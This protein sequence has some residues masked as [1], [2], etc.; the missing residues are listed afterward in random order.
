MIDKIIIFNTESLEG[1]YNANKGDKERFY[2]EWN[3]SKHTADTFYQMIKY[4][5]DNT[6][7]DSTINTVLIRQLIEYITPIIEFIPIEEKVEKVIYNAIRQKKTADVK[8]PLSKKKIVFKVE[9]NITCLVHKSKKGEYIVVSKGSTI[10]IIGF[11]LNKNITRNS[12]YIYNYITNLDNGIEIQDLINSGNI[13]LFNYLN[14]SYFKFGAKVDFSQKMFYFDDVKKDITAVLNMIIKL[15]KAATDYYDKNTINLYKTIHLM[16]F[17]GSL[18]PPVRETIKPKCQTII[19]KMNKILEVDLC[20]D[21]HNNIVQ[22]LYNTGYYE[23]FNKLNIGDV[24]TYSK[25]KYIMEKKENKIIQTNLVY[26]QLTSNNKYKNVTDE[27]KAKIIAINDAINNDDK[28]AIK[29]ALSKSPPVCKHLIYKGELLLKDDGKNEVEKN[30][31]IRNSLISNYSD[32]TLFDG[33]FCKLCGEELAKIDYTPQIAVETRN[34]YTNETYNELQVKIYREIS[35]IVTNFVDFGKTH[36]HSISGIIKNITDVIKGEMH[37]IEIGLLKIKTLQ[38]NEVEFTLGIYIYIYAFAF[39][40][41]LIYLNDTISFKK[42]LFHGGKVVVT[43]AKVAKVTTEPILAK[44]AENTITN[45]K[46]LQKIINSAI[47]ILTKIKA[48]DLQKSKVIS[49]SSIKDL[50]LKAYRWVLNINYA[51]M[52]YSTT[53]YWSQNNNIIDYFLY[54]HNRSLKSKGNS[55]ADPITAVLGRS[56]KTIEAEL[57]KNV[58]IYDTIIKPIKWSDNPYYNDSLLAIYDYINEQLYLENVLAKNSS[59]INYYAKYSY[60]LELQK[61]VQKQNKIREI[62]PFSRMPVIPYKHVKSTSG[63][64][65]CNCPDSKYIYQKINN[66]GNT[67]GVKREVSNKDINDWLIVKDYKKINE[68]NAWVVVDITCPCKKSKSTT[69]IDAF[70]NFYNLKCPVGDAHEFSIKNN[71]ECSKCHI[72]QDFIDNLNIA[73]YK[74]YKNVYEATKIKELS[75]FKL[76]KSNVKGKTAVKFP[77]YVK[78]LSAIK[79]LVLLLNINPNLINNL[80]LY[81]KQE[82]TKNKFD[83]DLSV[84]ITEMERLKQNNNLY[85]HYLFIIRTYYFVRGSDQSTTIPDY[86]VDFIKSFSN[87]GLIEKFPMIN[88]NF[89]DMYSYYKKHMSA[90]L[91]TNFLLHSIASTLLQ[92]LAIYEK[93]SLAVVGKKFIK[94]LFDKMID[95]EKKLTKFDIH[96]ILRF[97]RKLESDDSPDAEIETTE[98][99]GDYDIVDADIDVDYEEDDAEKDIFSIGDMDV[100]MDDDNLY[101]DVEDRT[102]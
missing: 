27:D 92:I 77:K 26:K 66:N 40:S 13:T 6:F 98:I 97:G 58:G 45:E 3:G 39:I 43:A 55:P 74:K 18:K 72:T 69:L 70:Y 29:T 96:K 4:E 81:E 61:Q 20:Y 7:T 5:N 54:A 21:N 73:Y 89:Q 37:S 91:N 78:D 12:A 17:N 33:Y 68:F 49:S 46:N 83:M 100:E 34:E 60:L 94:L 57:S 35:Y 28:V 50:F 25:L 1:D 95:N 87:V 19:N 32:T 23:Y 59:L 80:G 62:M 67:S 65:F 85:A 99:K 8:K 48:N 64:D 42:S 76:V 93:N 84:G 14:N 30:K 41:Q 10:D 63:I 38:T 53:G 22:N 56:Y 44:K 51:T 79:K 47:V 102:S 2:E 71:T 82:W 16:G 11:M 101:N 90:S 52:E 36:M 86:L 88:E 24:D 15:I 75:E 31:I 9:N